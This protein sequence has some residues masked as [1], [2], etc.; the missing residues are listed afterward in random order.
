[1][2]KQGDLM[3]RRLPSVALI[4]LYQGKNAAARREEI[5]KFDYPNVSIVKTIA[6]IP[7]DTDLC[8]FW[9]DDEKP[10]ARNF[11]GEMTRP[12]IAGEDFRAIMHFW[13][14][15]AISLPKALLDATAVDDD[16]A[17][18]QSLLG[19]LLPVLDITEKGATGRIHL[20]FSSTE[21]LA[22]MTMDPVGFP[23]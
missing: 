20:A 22:P 1:M 16:Q 4:W 21:R 7:A 8:V 19:L 3:K 15:N 23:S 12:L 5:E 6:D 11:I 2:F 13:S 10:V 17:G 14:G 18:V 9:K